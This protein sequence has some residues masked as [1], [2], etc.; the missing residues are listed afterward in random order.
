MA[1]AT[2]L[3]G[4]IVFGALTSLFASCDDDG[5]DREEP[6]GTVGVVATAANEPPEGDTDSRGTTV[7]PGV[8][9]SNLGALTS[10]APYNPSDG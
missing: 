9:A 1:G 5:A 3:T 8:P 7:E 2:V 6:A 4:V 10:Q